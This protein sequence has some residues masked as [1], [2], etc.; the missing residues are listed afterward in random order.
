MRCFPASTT[1]CQQIAA[2]KQRGLHHRLRLLQPVAIS[3]MCDQRLPHI[4]WEH[5]ATCPYQVGGQA[6]SFTVPLML[7]DGAA[8]TPHSVVCTTFCDSLTLN[9]E[10][11]SRW[12][13]SWREKENKQKKDTTSLEVNVAFSIVC[14]YRLFG[15]CTKH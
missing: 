2:S 4:P 7:Q 14:S 3:Q 9:T 15:R 10:H 5:S 13:L 8:G 6:L 1:P 11:K 12:Q